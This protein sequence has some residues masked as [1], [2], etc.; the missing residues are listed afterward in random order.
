M[1]KLRTYILFL[2]FMWSASY[3]SAQD[4]L[5][6]MKKMHQAYEGIENLFARIVSKEYEGKGLPLV[7]TITVR[8]KG[9]QYLY[10][11]DGRIILMNQDYL[12]AVDKENRQVVCTPQYEE[13]GAEVFMESFKPNLDSVL[14]QYKDIQ[15]LGVKN[16]LKH[17]RIEQLEAEI[18]SI[19]LF[20]DATSFLMKRIIYNYN[21]AEYGKSWVELSF[22]ILNTS[23]SF[24]SNTF[25]EA[26]YLKKV[27]GKLTLTEAYKGY[28]LIVTR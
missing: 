16:G 22:P 28:Q 6:D 19:E 2:L 5:Q 4:L 8:K 17:Y 12:I 26:K 13:E 24:Q 23:P 14:S 25:S 9:G 1:R 15:F 7:E 27:A 20:I 18:T 11:V 21:E 10:E 3:S